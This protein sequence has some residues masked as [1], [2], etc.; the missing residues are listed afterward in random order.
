VKLSLFENANLLK[1]KDAKPRALNDMA[2]G[3]PK[4]ANILL[5]EICWA[6]AK[7]IGL[8]K[9]NLESL[10]RA[11]EDAIK[12]GLNEEF[13]RLLRDEINVRKAA[14]TLRLCIRCRD[15]IE[16]PQANGVYPVYC[17]LCRRI[18][19]YEKKMEDSYDFAT[20]R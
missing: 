9:L 15:R 12:L 20:T 14:K 10:F 1:S 17:R 2:A 19:T 8:S 6:M 4:T 11:Y 16:R 7:Q 5:W 18:K 13:I 3:L